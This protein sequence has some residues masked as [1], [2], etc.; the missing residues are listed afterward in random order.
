MGAHLLL[1]IFITVKHY[2][3]LL[4]SQPLSRVKQASH[5]TNTKATCFMAMCPSCLFSTFHILI[6]FQEHLSPPTEKEAA[7]HLEEPSI[8]ALVGSQEK[9]H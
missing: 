9:L 1:V 3:N 6:L 8:L 2:Y 7:T 4:S 5:K